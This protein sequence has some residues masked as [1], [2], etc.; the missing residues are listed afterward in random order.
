MEIF[1]NWMNNLVAKPSFHSLIK[2]IPIIRRLAF[3][4]GK[5]IYDLVAGFVYSQVLLAII[6]LRLIDFLITGKKK[7]D[8]ISRFTGLPYDKCILLC[9]AAASVGLLKKIKILL[10]DLQELE[11]LLKEFQG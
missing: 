4:D 2:K 9:N 1:T 11:L 8:D 7:I 3:N 10:I 5:I 6:E